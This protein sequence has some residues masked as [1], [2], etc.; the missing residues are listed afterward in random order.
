MY[1]RFVTTRYSTVVEH[2]IEDRAFRSSV[3][4]DYKSV[5]AQGSWSTQP[6]RDQAVD[7]QIGLCLGLLA[8]TLLG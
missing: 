3:G 8:T 7:Y 2:C 6:H 4:Y 1:S 5:K